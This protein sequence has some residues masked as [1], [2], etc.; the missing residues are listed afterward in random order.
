[1]YILHSEKLVHTGIIF[2]TEFYV[3]HSEKLTHTGMIF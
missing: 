3:L 1:M 2:Y